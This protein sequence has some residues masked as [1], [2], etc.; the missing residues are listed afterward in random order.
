MYKVLFV[1]PSQMLS[2]FVCL[3]FTTLL[4]SYAALH[5]VTTGATLSTEILWLV[6]TLLLALLT[7]LNRYIV[8]AGTFKTKMRRNAQQLASTLLYTAS[9][10]AVYVILAAT[11][12]IRLATALL[13]VASHAPIVLI[14]WLASTIDYPEV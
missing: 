3:L 13:I 11:T 12:V 2:T 5:L 14:L 1:A 8:H 4:S 9:I 10:Q 6:A 7:A